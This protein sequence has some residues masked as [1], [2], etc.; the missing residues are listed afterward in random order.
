VIATGGGAVLREKNVSLLK[1]NGT[2]VFLDAPLEQLVA[3]PDRPLSSN[4]EAME[5][6]YRER[7]DVYLAAADLRVPVNRSLEENMKR[8]EEE[9]L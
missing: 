1:G 6:R 8:I 4:R 5:R 2:L 9:L 3:T 7:Y